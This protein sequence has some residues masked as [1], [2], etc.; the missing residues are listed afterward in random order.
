MSLQ[1]LGGVKPSLKSPWGGGGGGVWPQ[2]GDLLGGVALVGT[3]WG[4]GDP[5]CCWQ[6]GKLGRGCGD[7]ERHRNMGTWGRGGGTV[8]WGHGRTQ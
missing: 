6:K 3:V 2:N 5:S 7:M 1:C 8:M 4:G